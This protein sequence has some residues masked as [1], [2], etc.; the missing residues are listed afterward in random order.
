MEKTINAK[1]L[2]D[3]YWHIKNNEIDSN[4]PKRVERMVKDYLKSIN[5]AQSES[6]SVVDNEDEKN[7]CDCDIDTVCGLC[8][9]KKPKLYVKAMTE[10][11]KIFSSG[12]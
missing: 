9:S 6:Q 10:I 11:S 5:S 4:I 12:R 8:A 3:F 7:F 2:I 1:E